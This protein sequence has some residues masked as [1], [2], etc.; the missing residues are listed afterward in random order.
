MH[1][2]KIL[3][4]LTRMGSSSVLSGSESEQPSVNEIDT[5]LCECSAMVEL[6]HENVMRLVGVSIEAVGELKVSLVLPYMSGG[7]LKD[8]VLHR[9]VR[10]ILVLACLLFDRRFLALLE[11]H[12][13]ELIWSQLA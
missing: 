10:R 3:R 11:N 7:N 5:F 2:A 1:Y 13:N 9:P 4:V 8:Y 6:S 12:Q